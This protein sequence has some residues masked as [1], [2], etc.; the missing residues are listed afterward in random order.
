MSDTPRT[1][2][3]VPLSE[4]QKMQ[5]ELAALRER[6]ARLEADITALRE[7]SERLYWVENNL[8]RAGDVVDSTGR[9]TGIMKCWQVIT[10]CNDS[11]RETID[12]IRAAAVFSRDADVSIRPDY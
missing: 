4:W 6:N 2:E 7:D 12:A 3:P 9:V 8:C 10:Q 5:A 11:L 1:D